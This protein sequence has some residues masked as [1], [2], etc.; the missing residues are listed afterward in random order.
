MEP[1]LLLHERQ[2]NVHL[3]SLEVFIKN[4]HMNIT[5]EYADMEKV[6]YYCKEMRLCLV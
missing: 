6:G 5:V 1:T 4:F 2:A 3:G